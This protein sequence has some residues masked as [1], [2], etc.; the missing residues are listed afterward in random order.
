MLTLADQGGSKLPVANNTGRTL[1]LLD[2]LAFR[3]THLA[4]QTVARGALLPSS[5]CC[6]FVGLPF[7]RV[8]RNAIIAPHS[9]ARGAWRPNSTPILV[10]R[11][12]VLRQG[13]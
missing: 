7:T 5:T 12:G 11:I 3:D 9:V 4:P 13:G 8:V 6:S 2:A 10:L 1:L